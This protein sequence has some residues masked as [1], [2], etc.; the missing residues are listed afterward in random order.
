MAIA[1]VTDN[2]ISE[3]ISLAGRRAVVTGGARGLG[4]AIGRRLA[5]A[6]ASVL[7]ADLDEGL[8]KASAEAL[9]RELGAR[10]IATRL[11]V[12]DSASVT[13]AADLAAAELGGIDVWVN[14]AG[15]FP[16]AP[17][18]E[19]TDEL[20]DQVLDVNLKGSFVG[21]REAARRMIAAGHGGVIVN[22]ASTAGFR[23]TGPTLSA[24][25]SSKHGVRGLTRQ[26]ALELAPSDIR[27]LA[28][29]PTY[30]ATEGTGLGVIP[31][32]G[33]PNTEKMTMSRLGRMGEPDDVAR[34]VLFCASDLSSFMTGSTLPVD[35]GALA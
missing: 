16:S 3:L 15:V 32:D 14:N 10:V 26:L 22:V 6:G 7:L 1:D 18:L 9:S 25:V 33:G 28:V 4:R 27:V 34:V 30:I 17:L 21:A 23:G 24:Y 12:A 19:M 31:A 20:W 35:A 13:A 8:A 29:A 2:S 11:D 5:Q